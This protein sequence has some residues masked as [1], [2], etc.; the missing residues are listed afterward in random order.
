MRRTTLTAAAMLGAA[1][2]APAT[3]TA[4]V[5][6]T[7]Q[8]RPATIVGQ[9]ARTIA[10][11]EGP[12]VVVTNG[13]TE[14]RALGGDDL[15]CVTGKRLVSV[16]IDA[17]TGNDVVDARQS[18]HPVFGDLGAGADTFLGGPHDDRVELAYPD[19]GGGI[20]T[21]EGGAG[22]DQVQLQTGA[23]A[24][25]IDNAVGSF[26][27]AGTTLARWSGVEDFW[28]FTPP[29]PRD[30]TFVGSSGSDRLLHDS[31]EPSVVDVDL[32]GGDDVFETR[33]P[34][35]DG[36]RLAGGDGT[37]LVAIASAGSPIA[38]DLKHGQ[39][40]VR[41]P[42]PYSVVAEG[43]EDA[44][45]FAPEVLL[46]GTRGD[47]RLGVTACTGVVTGR[48]GDDVLVRQYDGTFET[49][50]DC[51]ESLILEG[52]PGNDRF[53]GSGG[54]DTILGGPGRDVVN[55][56]GGDDLVRG[57]GGADTI[58]G[59]GGR[60]TIYGGGG[61]DTLK[62]GKGRDTILGGQGRDVCRAERERSCER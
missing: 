23:G 35:L 53:V 14:V 54:D 55:G 19:A 17:G 26:T 32:G 31:W 9:A 62:G 46:A 7:C 8:G 34:P 61:K 27:S 10:G 3:S 20:D 40:D 30:L 15:V 37:D 59:R 41:L 1:L 44:E 58:T 42:A 33:T 12:D 51:R 4:A 16:T 49:D 13:A 22:H 29:A 25:V 38:L 50:L 57:N 21:V 52:D 48:S 36:S 45:V 2:L 56:R 6:D 18:P 28:V 11:T 24:A 47:N 43:F 60:D 39:L 5:A